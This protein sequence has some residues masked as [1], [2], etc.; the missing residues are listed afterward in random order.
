MRPGPRGCR[1]SRRTGGD[2]A[3]P[4]PAWSGHCIGAV[5]CPSHP[6][7][8]V[9]RA[10]S[11]AAAEADR[12]HVQPGDTL[13]GIA[14]ALQQQGVVGSVASLVRELVRLNGSRIPTESRW[15]QRLQLPPGAR[16]GWRPW[17]RDRPDGDRGA[18]DGACLRHRSAPTSAGRCWKG[19]C[20][21]SAPVSTDVPTS[22]A[23][24][25]AR[26]PCARGAPPRAGRNAALSP[27][28]P[29]VEG[30]AAGRRRR[31]ADAGPR[32]LCGH[33]LRHGSEP[34]ERPGADSRCAGA[35]S[36][37]ARRFPGRAGRLEPRRHGGWG[38]N[39]RSA[40]GPRPLDGGP[41]AGRGPAGAAPRARTTCRAS[42]ASTGSVSPAA[43]R[44]SGR[45]TANDPATGR[46]TAL[47]SSGDGLVT[48]R[49]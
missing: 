34:A 48:G 36:P 14:R 41:G 43:I 3:H 44:A 29:S 30:G 23:E 7:P 35:A 33:R 46:T 8:E 2:G 32:R 42:P 19:R 24:R 28:G 13:C 26:R 37:G 45:Y 12:W 31:G 27:G 49:R 39:A 10:E 40:G 5:A 1:T 9:G 16:R 47:V 22:I 4:P 15:G 21:G 25:S 38:R 18:I 20:S 11:R 6:W 17:A